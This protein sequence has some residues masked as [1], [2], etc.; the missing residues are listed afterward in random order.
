[1][2]TRRAA[3]RIPPLPPPGSP[4]EPQQPAESDAEAF[5]FL[6][7]PLDLPALNLYRESGDLQALNDASLNDWSWMVY[8]LRTPDEMVR[9]R[10]KH[11]RIFV[12]KLV[13]PLDVME[14]QRAVGG[15]VFEIRGFF[16]NRIQTCQRHE[17]AGPIRTFAPAA[18]VTE[19]NGVHMRASAPPDGTRMLRRMI[20]RQNR[21][22]R[23]LGETVSALRAAPVPAPA[24][25]SLDV[26][27]VFELAD[28]IHAR[29]NPHPEANVLDQMVSA[30]KS[31]M[32][33]KREV[34]G[35]PAR[36][37]TD[38]LVDKGI[39]ALERLL[40]TLLMTRR[41]APPRPPGPA[42]HPPSSA[43]VVDNP[44]TQDV[45]PAA[46]PGVPPAEPP[47]GGDDADAGGH[48]WATAIE[49]LARAV[50]EGQDPRD[51][52]IT[53]E[54]ILQPQE[55][56]I[57]RLSPADQ[58][59]A[60]LRSRAGGHLPVLNSEATAVFVREVVTEL[61]RPADEDDDDEGDGSGL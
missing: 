29:S 44:A 51:F 28:R 27:Q 30:F 6:D 38:T 40:G 39:P 11:Q 31:G 3:T 8:R 24:P 22:L 42:A 50:S 12:T 23:Q 4:L 54:A 57:L 7:D 37:L 14:L 46:T 13:G 59:T 20:R 33:V 34:D 17:L 47:A 60:M 52:S 16:N 55:I 15:G 26:L 10:S 53:L 2:A 35:E 9:D 36:T 61:N 32:E 1:M 58:V 45:A 21:Q 43:T 56:G 19:S 41:G 5:D 48:R 18:P 49:A 25:Q